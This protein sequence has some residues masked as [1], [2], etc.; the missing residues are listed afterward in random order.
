MCQ[1]SQSLVILKIK[2]E[3]LQDKTIQHLIEYWCYKQILYL[4]YSTPHKF[5]IGQKVNLVW[6]KQIYISIVNHQK[7]FGII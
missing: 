2:Q 7:W 6:V 3:I 5:K 4:I 1:T